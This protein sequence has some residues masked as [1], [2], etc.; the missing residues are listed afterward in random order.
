[1]IWIDERGVIV[2]LNDV[3]FGTD[4]FAVGALPSDRSSPPCE[5]GQTAQALCPPIGCVRSAHA[6]AAA[7]AGGV[8]ARLASASGGPSR[9]AERHFSRRRARAARLDDPAGLN[10]DP[11]IDPMQSPEFLQLWQEGLCLSCAAT[12]QG[13]R[14][15]ASDAVASS[16][17][18]RHRH[19]ERVIY[20]SMRGRRDGGGG[21]VRWTRV[22][23]WHE[24]GNQTS[25]AT[26]GGD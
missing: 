10:A 18:F 1:M 7:S 16:R 15:N 23:R 8:H 5:S 25:P 24:S 26:G 6:G 14:T 4:M 19:D 21:A 9:S 17:A 2:R 20:R 13:L 22:R 11:R 12:A 3:R